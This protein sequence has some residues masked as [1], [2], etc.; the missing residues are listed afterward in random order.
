MAKCII[1]EPLRLHAQFKLREVEFCAKE[2]L[3]EVE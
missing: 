2:E 3:T 1:F